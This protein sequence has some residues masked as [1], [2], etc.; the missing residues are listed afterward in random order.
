ME[1]QRRPLKLYPI[2]KVHRPSKIKELS[3]TYD[4]KVFQ[5]VKID[6]ILVQ[7]GGGIGAVS[8]KLHSCLGLSG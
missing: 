3:P 2:S 6:Q 4:S 5:L 8:F 1:Q 7:A